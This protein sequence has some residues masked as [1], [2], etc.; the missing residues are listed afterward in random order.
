LTLDSKFITFLMELRGLSSNAENESAMISDSD[1]IKVIFD[2]TR[3]M[4][5]ERS[6]LITMF[7]KYRQGGDLEENLTFR[8]CDE[9]IMMLSK[10]ETGLILQNGDPY[11]PPIRLREVLSILLKINNYIYANPEPRGPDFNHSSGPS[12]EYY[13]HVNAEKIRDD[14]YCLLAES[15]V[16]IS[17]AEYLSLAGNPGEAIEVWNQQKLKF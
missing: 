1:L 13:L 11:Q 12:E 2:K 16:G 6:A 10:N 15:G 17:K 14:I 9:L 3:N 8:L 4:G 5:F 7:S